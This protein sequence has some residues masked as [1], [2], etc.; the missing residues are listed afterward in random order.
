MTM[1]CIRIEY[2][3]ISLVLSVGISLGISYIMS[4]SDEALLTDN[5]WEN[6]S[7]E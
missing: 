5:Y 6:N 7:M 4:G 3:L 1:I 2:L